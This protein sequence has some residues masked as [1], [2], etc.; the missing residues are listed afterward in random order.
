MYLLLGVLTKLNVPCLVYWSFNVTHHFL[1]N[2]FPLADPIRFCPNEISTKILIQGKK[3]GLQFRIGLIK[4]FFF[5]SIIF[6]VRI[7]LQW[8]TRKELV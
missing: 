6:R 7:V 8:G 2:W 1:I 3:I 5:F 4:L